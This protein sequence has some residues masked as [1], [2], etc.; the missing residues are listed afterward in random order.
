MIVLFIKN[1]DGYNLVTTSNTSLVEIDIINLCGFIHIEMRPDYNR[2]F[3]FAVM[4]Y[5][6]MALRYKDFEYTY[7]GSRYV[8]HIRGKAVTVEEDKFYSPNG[9]Y[10][11][12]PVWQLIRIA[13]Y[14]GRF[15]RGDFG[16]EFLFTDELEYKIR[17]DSEGRW[18]ELHSD[19]RWWRLNDDDDWAE[20][21][22][23]ELPSE[24]S[25]Q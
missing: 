11:T 12:L 9:G 3:L 6:Y 22:T 10:Y 18:E 14:W 20:L 13:N 7:Y 16:T 15:C 8:A 21:K 24:V 19:G 25:E 5:L 4:P 2:P 1:L 17:Q 23:R